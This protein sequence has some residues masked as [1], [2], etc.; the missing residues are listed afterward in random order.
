MTGNNLK[1]VRLAYGYKQKDFAVALGV[2]LSCV[3]MAEV[4][5]RKIT[6]SLRFK[7]AR[8]FPITPEIQAVIDAAVA[9]GRAE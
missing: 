9:L 1:S 4:G 5:K 3:A 8:N 7:V 6:D 2:S